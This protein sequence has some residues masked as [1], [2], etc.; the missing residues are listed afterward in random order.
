M[1]ASERQAE[2]PG[3]GRALHANGSGDGTDTD[4][5]P[6]RRTVAVTRA[7]GVPARWLERTPPPSTVPGTAAH[8]RTDADRLVVLAADLSD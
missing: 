4:T 8:T 1:L 6:G 3:R 7:D 5:V 2:R